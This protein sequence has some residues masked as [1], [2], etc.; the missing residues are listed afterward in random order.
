MPEGGKGR[1]REW[2]S[3]QP[4]SSLACWP[5]PGAGWLRGSPHVVWAH[6]TLSQS[7]CV[8]SAVAGLHAPQGQDSRPGGLVVGAVIVTSILL[9]LAGAFLEGSRF[10]G[11]VVQLLSRVRLFATPRTVARQAS[12]FFTM[13]RSLLRL[14]STGHEWMH[15]I[16][17]AFPSG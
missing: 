6:P 14:M 2:L 12:L 15:A 9:F 7:H 11:L 13:S 17:L 1:Q 16:Q 8:L 5:R 3:A 4:S 10:W